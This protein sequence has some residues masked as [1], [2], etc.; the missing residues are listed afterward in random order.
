MYIQIALT[1]HANI[2]FKNDTLSE[3]W[4]LPSYI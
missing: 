1:Y 2:S 4:D 3:H